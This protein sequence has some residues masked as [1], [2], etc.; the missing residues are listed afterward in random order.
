MFGRPLRTLRVR[1]A[2]RRHRR[3]LPVSLSACGIER[4]DRRPPSRGRRI[5]APSRPTA[6]N[7]FWAA[8][9]P[10]GARR[11]NARGG[12]GRG[13]HRSPRC[14]TKA[15]EAIHA[16]D[17][18]ASL[19]RHRPG[20]RGG[21]PRRL[22]RSSPTATPAAWRRRS[23]A[24]RWPSCSRPPNRV[25]AFTSSPTRR[26]PC[27]RAPGSTTWELQQAGIDRDA[28]LR[29]HS[30]AGD[31]GGPHPTRHRRGRPHRQPTA[32]RPTRSAPTASLCWPTPT[33]SR[34]TLPPKSPRS[35]S[36]H[37]TATAFPIEQRDPREVT[38]GFGRQTAPDGIAVYN[39]AFDVTPAELIAGLITEKGLIRPVTEKPRSA[40]D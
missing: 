1:G 2:D 5:P 18:V 28:H 17:A 12:A 24:P 33:A 4:R 15:P 31:E 34:Y 9:G 37:P 20:R 8:A 11:P 7:L 14:S 39:P 13:A 23:T 10:Y 22:R 29:Q 35:T 38:H 32:T 26:V 25:G 19:P 3:R 27:S 21:D 6:I 36:A 16:E 40:N 30:R